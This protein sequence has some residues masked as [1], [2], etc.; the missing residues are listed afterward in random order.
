MGWERSKIIRY[1]SEKAWSSINHSI[2]SARRDRQS[3]GKVPNKA[4]TK[5]KWD[6]CSPRKKKSK[7]TE[8]VSELLIKVF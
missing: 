5:E 8:K 6:K 2:L 4:A 3:K 7:D 1:D